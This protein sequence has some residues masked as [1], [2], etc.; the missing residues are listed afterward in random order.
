MNIGELKGMN[1]PVSLPYL[2]HFIS[3]AYLAYTALFLF[4]LHLPTFN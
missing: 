4:S 3:L 1:L 2:H